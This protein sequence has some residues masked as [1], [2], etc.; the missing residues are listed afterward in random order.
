MSNKPCVACEREI[1]GH[2][3]RCAYCKADQPAVE[4]R[5]AGTYPDPDTPGLLRN[6]NGSS[7]TGAPFLPRDRMIEGTPLV[8]G[9]YPRAEQHNTLGYWD[10]ESFTSFAP[11]SIKVD[12]MSVAWGVVVGWLI[13]GAISAVVWFAIVAFARGN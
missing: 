4:R 11:A 9:W 7:W 10:G 8:P 6:W 2:A 13:A 12:V 1:A 3:T 5:K